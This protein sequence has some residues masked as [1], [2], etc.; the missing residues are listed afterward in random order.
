MDGYSYLTFDQRREIE[1]LY[2]DGERAVD[3]AAKIG[4]SVAAIYEELKRGYTGEL[5][6]NKRPVYSA[7][8]AQTTALENIRRRGKRR[9]ANQQQEGWLFN[10]KK[11]R[12]GALTVS[13]KGLQDTKE[14][15]VIEL[16]D[17][18]QK[19]VAEGKAAYENR[20]YTEEQK[21][22]TITNLCGRFCGLAEFLQITMG[23][24]VRRAD[25]LLYTQEMYNHFHYWKM[26]LNIEL[27][28]ENDAAER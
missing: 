6:E 1:A 23:I 17:R 14:E 16:I 22:N 20:D 26:M 10:M 27:E 3:I 8:L 9:A 12:L 5:D 28:K 19:Y 4:R 13:D 11:Y 15:I 7:D 18:M 25:G 2:S 24:D 21:L